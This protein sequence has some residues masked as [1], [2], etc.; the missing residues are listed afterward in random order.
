MDG[1]INNKVNLT[2]YL[3]NEEYISQIFNFSKSTDENLPP[4]KAL[5]IAH[6]IRKFKHRSIFNNFK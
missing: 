6:A 5:N 2:K 4:K 3:T 1:N